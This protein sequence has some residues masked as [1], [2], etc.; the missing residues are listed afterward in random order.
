MSENLATGNNEDQN[1]TIG[2]ILQQ[3]RLDLKISVAE[4]A[5]Y[6][7][8]KSH[9]IEAIE[10]DDLKLITKHL[11]ILGLIRSYA[12]FLKINAETLEQ[13]IK[14]ISIKSNIDNKEHKLINI[15]EHIDLVP[16]KDMFFNFLL[17]ATLLFFVLISLI[18]SYE[19]NSSFVGSDKII[20][21]IEKLTLQND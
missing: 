16:E 14:S 11:Y 6:L 5:S 12:K 15:G 9:D 8:V 10:S 13:K 4:A 3:K 19:D 2:K 18:G 1:L 7:R 21:E 17:I 20:G